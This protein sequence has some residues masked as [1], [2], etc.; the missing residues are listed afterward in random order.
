MQIIVRPL[1]PSG[2]QTA[3]GAH[4]IGHGLTKSRAALLPDLTY[5]EVVRPRCAAL[6]VLTIRAQRQGGSG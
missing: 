1:P 2:I 6:A 5:S 3:V 4:P